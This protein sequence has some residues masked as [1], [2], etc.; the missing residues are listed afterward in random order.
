MEVLWLTPKPMGAHKCL[1]K[2]ESSNLR[3]SNNSQRST[4]HLR[5]TQK[6]LLYC[7][8]KYFSF[9]LHTRFYSYSWHSRDSMSLLQFSLFKVQQRASHPLLIH[10]RADCTPVF[11]LFYLLV[12]RVSFKQQRGC[13]SDKIYMVLGWHLFRL[14][15]H[16]SGEHAA[17][18]LNMNFKVFPSISFPTSPLFFFSSLQMKLWNKYKVTSIPSLVF[19]DAATG[20]VV[21]RNGLLVVRDD[22]KGEIGSHTHTHTHTRVVYY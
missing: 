14:C 12:S 19:V 17:A 18:A 16:I 9:Q 15:C 5:R 3:S 1:W 22:P 2:Y 10:P 11:F 20:K 21:C 4:L 8:A 13:L 6:C 7:R